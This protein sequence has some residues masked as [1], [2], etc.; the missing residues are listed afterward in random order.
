MEIDIERLA[1]KFTSLYFAYFP[2]IEYNVRG[3]Y[4]FRYD[5]LEQTWYP[6]EYVSVTDLVKKTDR[7]YVSKLYGLLACSI[8]SGTYRTKEKRREFLD[9]CFSRAKELGELI[10][11][12][13][14]KPSSIECAGTVAVEYRVFDNVP[15]PSMIKDLVKLVYNLHMKLCSFIAEKG[16]EIELKEE[17][18]DAID[19]MYGKA[20][21]EGYRAKPSEKFIEL[22]EKILGI[23]L[24][25]DYENMEE[26]AKDI[27]DKLRIDI[28]KELL[29]LNKQRQNIL[30]LT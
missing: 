23:E 9:V 17:L 21:V 8:L 18:L 10:I 27:V 19:E 20:C 6:E 2:S 30:E 7:K 15:D 13:L 5:D 3:D 28:N 11:E 4:R 16:N 29:E 22:L 12:G 24:R 1:S 14:H 26:L 25:R